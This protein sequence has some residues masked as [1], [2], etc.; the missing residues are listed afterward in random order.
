MEKQGSLFDTELNNSRRTSSGTSSST[1]S[2]VHSA[3]TSVAPATAS[4]TANTAA[5]AAASAAASKAALVASSAEVGALGSSASALVDEQAEYDPFAPLAARLRPRNLDEY[6]GQSH[7]LSPRQA[8]TSGYR[9]WPLLLHDLL[10]AAR[11]R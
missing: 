3:S 2:S 1:R 10:G 7:L 11:C 9:E 4:A 5:P 8:F 6:I